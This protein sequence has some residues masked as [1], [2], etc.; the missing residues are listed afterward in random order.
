[1]I[2]IIG[3]SKGEEIEGV[4]LSDKWSVWGVARDTAAGKEYE[5]QWRRLP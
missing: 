3:L 4:A 1:M 2:K 5:I